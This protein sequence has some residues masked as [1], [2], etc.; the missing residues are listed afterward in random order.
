[1]LSYHYSQRLQSQHLLAR[2]HTRVR[3]AN[4]LETIHWITRTRGYFAA[5]YCFLAMDKGLPSTEVYWTDWQSV[6]GGGFTV[7]WTGYV[8]HVLLDDHLDLCYYWNCAL[9]RRTWV[10]DFLNGDVY[11]VHSQSVQGW[12]DCGR[13][14]R[15]DS[16][17]SIFLILYHNQCI[18]IGQLDCGLTSPRLQEVCCSQECPLSPLYAISP[19]DFW[20]RQK[21]FSSSVSSFP[22]LCA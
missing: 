1:V 8:C 17:L 22:A 3:S 16:V 13:Q 9:C 10:P 2:P 12:C 15:E 6:L 4:I 18:L 21:V 11:L 20:S 14:K 5:N 7:L 19:W